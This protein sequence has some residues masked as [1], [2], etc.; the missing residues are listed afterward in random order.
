M[1]CCDGNPVLFGMTFFGVIFFLIGGGCW[2]SGTDAGNQP[3]RIAGIA[4]FT[5]GSFMIVVSIL[6]LMILRMYR[7]S[8]AAKKAN[9]LLAQEVIVEVEIPQ[10]KKPQPEPLRKQSYA[11]GLVKQEN[12][13]V[14]FQPPRPINPSYINNTNFN[15]PINN[16]PVARNTA[17]D[18][19]AMK[20]D[21]PSAT[22]NHVPTQQEF[23]PQHNQQQ[24][25]APPRMQAQ[26][27]PNATRQQPANE[28]PR[29]SRQ[30]DVAN[31][32]CYCDRS[33]RQ[34]EG[35]IFALLN[36]YRNQLKQ[37]QTVYV[38]KGPINIRNQN[39]RSMI[40]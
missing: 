29:Q 17:Y 35:C 24:N 33:T 25:Y 27:L 21:Y 15:P 12:E 11:N 13:P 22:R 28:I 23:I 10:D 31:N 5:I 30:C 20:N 19:N 32:I 18:N 6:G 37:S 38:M 16:Q 36:I 40:I 26:T 3:E 8:K 34:A 39:K 7:A 2:G 4:L 9:L 14:N 1:V